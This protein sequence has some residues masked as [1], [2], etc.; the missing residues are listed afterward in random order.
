MNL[1]S[2]WEDISVEEWVDLYKIDT[3]KSLSYYNY[4]INKLSILLDLDI[5]DDYWDD[6]DLDDLNDMISSCSF[7]NI[8]PSSNFKKDIGDFK[9]I[10][11]KNITLGEW[12][13][14][15]SYISKNFITNF[16]HILSILWRRFK[17]DEWGNIIYE[18][19]NFDIE[20]RSLFFESVCINDV[21]GIIKIILEYRELIINSYKSILSTSD[22]SELTEE[23]KEGLSEEDIIEIEDEIKKDKLKSDFS[24][25]K[26]VYDLCNGDLTKTE[27][28]L[29]LKVTY[30]FNVQVMLDIFK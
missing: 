1:K 3:D 13:D 20:Q 23:D 16:T 8:P 12:I 18:K 29:N 15:D 24:W 2:S 7:I 26:F 25:M 4:N 10:N 21:F 5:E 22:D 30:V 27:D 17:E 14:L 19:Y 9:L 28:I 6:L 11:L